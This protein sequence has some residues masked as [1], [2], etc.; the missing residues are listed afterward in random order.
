MYRPALKIFSEGLD[1]KAKIFFKLLQQNN[2]FMFNLLDGKRD[3]VN[4]N[5]T[6]LPRPRVLKEKKVVRYPAYTK[7]ENDTFNDLNRIIVPEGSSIDW[8]IN[9]KSI[10]FCS[11]VFEDS[12]VRS[13]N[14]AFGFTYSPNK[15]QGYKIFVKNNFSDF[16]DS[17]SYFIELVKDGSPSIEVNEVFDSNKVNNRLFIGDISDDYGFSSLKFFCLRNDSVIYSEHLNYTGMNLSLIHI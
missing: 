3:T 8:E 4:Y 9:C 2:S 1:R 13:K 5:V 12:T 7:M 10:S 6:V 11:A 14:E 16:T 15:S 17:L